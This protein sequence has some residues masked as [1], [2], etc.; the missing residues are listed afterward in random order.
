MANKALTQNNLQ[1][2][3]TLGSVF[4]L[5]A[6]LTLKEGQLAKGMDEQDKR[7]EESFSFIDKFE[8]LMQKAGYKVDHL[9]KLL[10]YC[11]M[12][13]SEFGKPV[14]AELK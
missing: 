3:Y 1:L 10:K 4:I 6:M 12:L 2:D 9:I 11:Q 8:I 5:K 7:M 13:Q 14:D